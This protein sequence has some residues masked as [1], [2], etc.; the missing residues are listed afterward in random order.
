LVVSLYP[1]YERLSGW[2]GAR[3]R[4][5]AA[6]LT[7]VTLLVLTLPAVWL[8]ITVAESVRSIY[9]RIDFGSINLLTPP[10]SVK[11]WRL[12]GDKIYRLWAFAVSNLGEMLVKIGPQLKAVAGS[13]L[14]VSANAGLGTAAFVVS[15]I[16]AGFVYPAAPTLLR[17]IRAFARKLD[18]DRGERFVALSGSTIR[19]VARG[20][21]GISALQ[22]LMAGIGFAAAGIPQ[23]S[24]LTF[25][26]LLFGIVQI[27]AAVIIIP[28]IVWSWTLLDTIP[29]IVFT[30][31]MLVVNMLDNIAKPFLMGRGLQ[32]PM[33]AIL[34]GVVGGALSYGLSG[35]FLGPI[36]LTVVWALFTAWVDEPERVSS[37]P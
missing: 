6:L 12:I 23:A 21:V 8:A 16:V 20:V 13:F 19:A 4:L 10:E 28:V 5:A 30:I 18:P 24:L 7:I 11:A 22:S 1:G 9:E 17:Y 3:R 31:Y 25:A 32:V 37:G 36:V 29:A 26:V 14:R 15:I 2:L 27:G 34:V 33:L 35:V